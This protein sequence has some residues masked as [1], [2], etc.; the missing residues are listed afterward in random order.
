MVATATDFIS[1]A[2]LGDWLRVDASDDSGRLGVARDSAISYVERWIG[3]AILD[4]TRIIYDLRP[5]TK[6]AVLLLD[7]SFV[8]SG[9]AYIDGP[10][11]VNLASVQ[12]VRNPGGDQAHIVPDGRRTL[13]RPPIGGWSDDV[14]SAV[15]DFR[16]ELS[17]GATASDIDAIWKR[18]ALSIAL[19]HYDGDVKVIEAAE[20][21]AQSDLISWYRWART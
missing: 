1:D 6:S 17:V 13:I 2:E 21:K 12:A 7:V 11:R 10:D 20:S 3:D 19:A 4:T 15:G 14:V 9:T 16:I 8:Q 18:T 5:A